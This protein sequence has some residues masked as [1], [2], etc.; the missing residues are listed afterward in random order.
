LIYDIKVDQLILYVP[1]EKNFHDIV[2]NGAGLTR[3]EALEKY[4]CDAVDYHSNLADLLRKF[5]L[6]RNGPLFILHPNDLEL[7]DI[8]NRDLIDNVSLMP[9]MNFCRVI[10]DEHEIQYIREA[11]RISGKAHTEV[12]RAITTLEN[13]TSVE[14][15]FKGVCID[16]GAKHQAYGIIAAS[17]RNAATLHYMKNDE[18]LKGRELMCLDAGCEWR[19][20][21][22]DVTRTFPLSGDGWPS[23]EAKSIYSLVEKMQHACISQ[24]RPG[25]LYR[26]LFVLA[27]HVLVEGLLE[28][29]IFHNGTIEEIV[30][31]GTSLSL[32]PHGLGHHM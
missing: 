6:S 22:C 14:A 13:E 28:L 12:L 31:A 19:N 10:K 4:D 25:V 2:W 8:P 21:A 17:G 11:N 26:D 7:F 27:H 20:Y 32:F 9:A 23:A 18:P 24:I 15:I 1:D 16:H 29:G 30:K 5:L 3:K